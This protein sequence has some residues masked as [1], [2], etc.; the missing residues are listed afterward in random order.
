VAERSG[1]CGAGKAI[2]G[3]SNVPT[4]CWEPSDGMKGELAR[5]YL[6]M[7]IS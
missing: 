4:T 5:V 6:Y 7:S 1:L 3:A 2:P